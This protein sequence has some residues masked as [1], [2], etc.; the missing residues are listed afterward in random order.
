MEN[1]Y[2]IGQ[3]VVCSRLGKGT[4][5]IKAIYQDGTIDIA[6][7]GARYWMNVSIQNITPVSRRAVV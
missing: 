1:N 6:Y 5:T 7:P 3:K 2:R 4:A